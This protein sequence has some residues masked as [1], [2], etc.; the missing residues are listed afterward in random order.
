MVGYLPEWKIYDGFYP[1]NL[2]SSGSADKLTHILYAFANISPEGACELGDAWADYETPVDANSS[3]DGVADGGWGTLR[4]NFN[5]L[6]KL[7]K[8]YP[9]LKLLISIGGWS[10]SG[11][12]SATASTDASRKAFVSSCVDTFIRGQFT[13]PANY[14]ITQPG[15]FDGIDID[16][17]YPGACGD[18]CSYSPADT[19]NF[20]LLLAEFRKQLDAEGATKKT[21]YLLSIAAPA[22]PADYSLIQLSQIPQY[23]D[24]V[25]LMTYDLNGGW[26]NY[27][28][29]GAPL[30]TAST[31]PIAADKR[32]NGDST[33]SAYLTGG[34]PAAKLNLGIPFYGHGWMGVPQAN[35]GLYQPATGVAPD[36]QAN[37]NVL[38]GLAGFSH[39][40]DSLSGN[41]HWIY[42]A[43]AKTF[44]SYD[45]PKTVF[46]KGLYVRGRG[47][48]GAMFWDLSGDDSQG[49]LIHAVDAGMK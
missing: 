22:A 40:Y 28:D 19:Q 32:N 31:D 30:Y 39:Y 2:V 1:K 15:L 37:Y 34:V 25:N 21:H 16:W 35:H 26:N 6:V 33:V 17:E 12:F 42:S 24:F 44:Y 13:D 5:Q 23:L 38:Q 49:S 8:V 14:N 20:T 4:G 48:G 36:D 29:H 43:A 41:A 11:N 7:K 27:A 46:A 18:T 10:W 47:L 45:D 3:I 9:S